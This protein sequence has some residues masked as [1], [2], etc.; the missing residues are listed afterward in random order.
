MVTSLK[1]IELLFFFLRKME[2]N[3]MAAMRIIVMWV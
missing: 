1:I 3:N 2:N